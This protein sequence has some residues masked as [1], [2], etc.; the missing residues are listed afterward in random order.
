MD[1]LFSNSV[2]TIVV[3][4]VVLAIVILLLK[5]SHGFKISKDGIEFAKS[6]G[7]TAAREVMREAL[8][9]ADIRIDYLKNILL[10]DHPDEKYFILWICSEI[11]NC[12]EM[13]INFNSIEN[14]ESYKNFRWTTLETK[15]KSVIKDNWSFP[16]EET[17]KNFCDWVSV[18]SNI[19][20][21][22]KLK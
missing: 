2:S 6:E 3:G 10:R 19:K 9:D 21:I 17:Y 18:V 7:E 15:I 4:V 16:F 11:R 1:A 5:F 12:I 14:T 22:K 8:V 13:F 20:K